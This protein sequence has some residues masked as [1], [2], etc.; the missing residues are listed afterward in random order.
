ML[1]CG[2]SAEGCGRCLWVAV[3]AGAEHGED[4]TWM[5]KSFILL[6]PQLVQGSEWGGK[7]PVPLSLTDHRLKM[8]FFI[9]SKKPPPSRAGVQQ[10][11]N[12]G[13]L[14]YIPQGI[15]IET[16]RSDGL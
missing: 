2:L 8:A 10:L 9:S 1:S 12:H 15:S 13:G 14:S 11:C 7:I 16:M 4:C 3:G 5:N 6:L